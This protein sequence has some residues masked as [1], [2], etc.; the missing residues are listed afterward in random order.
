MFA[1]AA[2]GCASASASGGR[3]SQ[4][5][6]SAGF[7]KLATVNMPDAIQ[8][9]D[10][11]ALTYVSVAGGTASVLGGGKFAN[12]A[13]T[14]AFGYVFNQMS[15]KAPWEKRELTPE[16]EGMG[17]VRLTGGDYQRIYDKH[18]PTTNRPDS[19]S[20]FYPELISDYGTFVDKIVN[21]AL[22]PGLA[23]PNIV[24]SRGTQN[25]YWDRTLPYPVGLSEVG[26]P[27]NTVTLVL[28]YDWGLSLNQGS[29][30]WRVTGAFPK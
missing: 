20:L 24:Y 14:A 27:T 30:I 7:G 23:P 3:C 29:S 12:G 19:T 26:L 11:Y 10:A 2:V 22:G 16:A 5:A 4:G 13:V 8:A 15:G 18:N 1:H 25:L 9:N 28:R 6:L 21:P 17:T